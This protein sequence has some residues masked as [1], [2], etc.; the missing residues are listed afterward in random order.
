MALRQQAFKYDV[1]VTA[2][3]DIAKAGGVVK[4]IWM[5]TKEGKANAIETGEDAGIGQL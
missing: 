1:D 3:A 4:K 2:E 5:M